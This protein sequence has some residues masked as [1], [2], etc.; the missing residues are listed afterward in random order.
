M[1]VKGQAKRIKL[2]IPQAEA[3]CV[4]CGSSKLRCV[5]STGY[6]LDFQ[7]L[8]PKRCKAGQ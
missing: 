1:C 5:V 2:C 4:K 8:V 6:T 7:D 3:E